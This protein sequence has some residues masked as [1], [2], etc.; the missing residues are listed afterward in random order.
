MIED[1]SSIY[2]KYASLMKYIPVT[3]DK[4]Y[5]WKK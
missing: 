5:I 1:A 2:L 3:P 4:K